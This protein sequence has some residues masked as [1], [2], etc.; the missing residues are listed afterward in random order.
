[1]REGFSSFEI[2]W[3]SLILCF[4]SNLKELA[5]S[6]LNWHLKRVLLVD[7]S[8]SPIFDLWILCCEYFFKLLKHLLTIWRPVF[9][10]CIHNSLNFM[11]LHS[12]RQVL[13]LFLVKAFSKQ[14]NYSII[15]ELVVMCVKPE[16]VERPVLIDWKLAFFEDCG[17]VASVELLVLLYIELLELC[18]FIILLLKIGKSYIF[19]LRLDFNILDLWL[20]RLS[21]KSARSLQILVF[22]LIIWGDFLFRLYRCLMRNLD[23]VFCVVHVFHVEL[24]FCFWR[25]LVKSVCILKI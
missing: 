16:Y 7:R 24:E 14:V 5:C 13:V 11:H 6:V 25:F 12:D 9:W 18:P 17:W 4:I 1:M 19:F 2:I 10:N 8:S 15:C 23:V 22:V 21:N 3:K 20:D